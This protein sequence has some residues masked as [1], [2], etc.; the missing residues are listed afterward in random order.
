MA[1]AY[2]NNKNATKTRMTCPP[3]GVN[4]GAVIHKIFL[5]KK[6]SHTNTPIV[7]IVDV[8]A[9]STGN[10]FR[11][12]RYLKIIYFEVGRYFRAVNGLRCISSLRRT[13]CFDRV[14]LD[15]K[16]F[17]HIQLQQPGGVRDCFSI[18]VLF[19]VLFFLLCCL[20]HEV[21]FHLRAS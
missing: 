13:I 14:S 3:L 10:P 15:N 9:F 11:G 7:A 18:V 12:T 21:S 6:C 17:I 16:S 2:N 8:N 20:F 1:W 5:A 4:G 19:F